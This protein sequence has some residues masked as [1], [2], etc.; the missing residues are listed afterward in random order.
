MP[1]KGNLIELDSVPEKSD[2]NTN[3]Y[4]KAEKLM[5]IQRDLGVSL[6]ATNE[7]ADG[8][9][10]CL[11]ATIHAAEEMDCC[12]IYLLNDTKDL[13]ESLDAYAKAQMEFNQANHDA[14]NAL[15]NLKAAVGESS[16]ENSP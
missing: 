7:L 14:L 15:E 8:L 4:C 1:N 3:S 10:H 2:K 5:R 9:T 12:G 11:E 13:L 6:S 16:T